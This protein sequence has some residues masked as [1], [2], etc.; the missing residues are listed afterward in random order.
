MRGPSMYHA[1]FRRGNAATPSMDRA[2]WAVLR[3]LAAGGLP[4][5]AGSQ[6]ADWL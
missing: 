4:S 3:R 2:G 5:D 1:G 6:V